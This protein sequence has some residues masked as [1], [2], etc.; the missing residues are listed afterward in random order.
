MI[1]NMVQKFLCLCAVPLCNVHCNSDTTR[2]VPSGSQQSTNKPLEI[3]HSVD[4]ETDARITRMFSD[5]GPGQ[6][7]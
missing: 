7:P 2:T 4:P 6:W 5:G 3:L 1:S